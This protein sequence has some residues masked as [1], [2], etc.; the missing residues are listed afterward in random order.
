M[1]GCT[2]TLSKGVAMIVAFTNYKVMEASYLNFACSHTRSTWTSAVS[3]AHYVL[4]NIVIVYLSSLSMCDDHVLVVF[5]HRTVSGSKK[6]EIKLMW[7]KWK[8]VF[9]LCNTRHRM[10]IAMCD[11]FSSLKFALQS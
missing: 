4:L 10:D 11:T 5:N 7:P 9:L 1:Q 3:K 2:R 6:H 8:F